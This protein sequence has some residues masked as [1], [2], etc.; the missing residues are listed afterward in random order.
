MVIFFRATVNQNLNYKLIYLFKDPTGVRALWD[1]GNLNGASQKVCAL[2][3]IYNFIF[4]ILS[5]LS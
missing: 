3:L 5:F 4:T 1:R 2:I